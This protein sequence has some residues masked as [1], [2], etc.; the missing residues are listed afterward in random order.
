MT[1]LF[2]RSFDDLSTTTQFTVGIKRLAIVKFAAIY[3]KFLERVKQDTV[4]EANPVFQR[5]RKRHWVAAGG[6]EN[7]GRGVSRRN[8]ARQ[9]Q[10][11]PVKRRS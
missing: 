6:G 2:T 3:R 9:L 1:V 10:K 11:L 4:G 7:R 8:T 5:L